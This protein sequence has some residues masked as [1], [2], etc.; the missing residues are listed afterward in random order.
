L[1]L[2]QEARDSFDTVRAIKHRH[3]R[4]RNAAKKQAA[5]G[6][7]ADDVGGLGALRSPAGFFLA[8]PLEEGGKEEEAEV[9]EQAP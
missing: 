7:Q 2:C 1:L 3:A 5:S 6:Q 9:R 8:P 4:R